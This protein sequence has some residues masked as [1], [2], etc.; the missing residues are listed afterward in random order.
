MRK[1]IMA[2]MAAALLA[3]GCS[4]GNSETAQGSDPKPTPKIEGVAPEA[5]FSKAPSGTYVT[6]PKHRYITFTYLHQGYS[7]PFLRW[8]N[9]EGELTWNAEDPA[10]SLIS[11]IIDTESIDS[12]VDMF[13]GH[14]KSEGFFNAEAYPEITFVST[15][16]ERTSPRAGKVTGDLT[17]KG[18][19][20]PVTLDVVFNKADAAQDGGHKIGFSAKGTVMRSDYG[21]DKYV[22]MIS[23]E[24]EVI[25]EAELISSSN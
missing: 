16:A 2:S 1:S 12:G 9:W 17:I 20:K 7:H 15:K 24:V 19:T 10:A 13:D 5:E 11:V 4:Q 3:L 23:D 25:I 21:L 8:R 14:L 22:P 6:D 18:V